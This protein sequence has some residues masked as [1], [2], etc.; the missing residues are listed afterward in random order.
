MKFLIEYVS[1]MAR[2]IV[3]CSVILERN[4]ANIRA[5]IHRT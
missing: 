2:L 5:E 1:I 3:K 4:L